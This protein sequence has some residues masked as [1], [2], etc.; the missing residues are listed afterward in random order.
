MDERELPIGFEPAKYEERAHSGRGVLLTAFLAAVVAVAVMWPI[1]MGC[2]RGQGTLTACK[3]NCMNVATALEMW[4]SDHGGRYPPSVDLLTPGYLRTLPT[5][6]AAGRDTYSAS[7]E[8]SV[9]PDAFSF[10]CA[11]DNHRKA[12]SGF[13][14]PSRNFPKYNAMEGLLDHP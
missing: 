12:Y 11:G 2:S 7:Y 13:S 4:A 1:R 10:Y 6:P 8:R 9:Q 14:A 5:C 3:S